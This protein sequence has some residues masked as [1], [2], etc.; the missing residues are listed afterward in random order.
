MYRFILKNFTQVLQNSATHWVALYNWVFQRIVYHPIRSTAWGWI[1]YWIISKVK[2]NTV[3]KIITLNKAFW[4]PMG[5][6]FWQNHH[7]E[8]R[9]IHIQDVCLFHWEK[10]AISSRMEVVQ[11]NQPYTKWLA[12][13][14]WEWW[15]IVD[16]VLVSIAG[17]L[18]IHNAKAKLVFVNINPCCWQAHIQPPVLPKWP[19]SSWAYW[20]RVEMAGE[21]GWLTSTIWVNWLLRFTSAEAVLW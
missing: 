4:K 1:W 12:G 20:A 7:R 2:S 11:C 8:G 9:Q 6:W 14:P 5:G 18:G 13:V 16:S 10:S 3:R 19:P 17:R 15:H 21:R